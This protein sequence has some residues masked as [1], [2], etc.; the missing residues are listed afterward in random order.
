[1]DEEVQAR[2]PSGPL[3]TGSA[4]CVFQSPGQV[5]LPSPSDLPNH[6][7]AGSLLVLCPLAPSAHTS[8]G[9]WVSELLGLERGLGT[10]AWPEVAVRGAGQEHAGVCS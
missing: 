8:F 2:D 4:A 10:A 1:M 5:P 3:L 7:P 6:S 9:L